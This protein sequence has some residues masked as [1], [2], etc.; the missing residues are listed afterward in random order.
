MLFFFFVR[1][2]KE[3]EDKDGGNSSQALVVWESGWRKIS[4][5]AMSLSQN[6]SFCDKALLPGRM[7]GAITLTWFVHLVSDRINQAL[8][9]GFDVLLSW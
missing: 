3:R 8:I 6:I 7:G 1:W 2:R 9:S 4:V 5:I